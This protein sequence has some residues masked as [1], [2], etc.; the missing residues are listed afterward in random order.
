MIEF[1]NITYKYSSGDAAEYAALRSLSL[2]IEKG[3]FIGIA[4]HTGSGKSTAA[5]IAAGLINPTSGEILIDGK[6]FESAAETA[7]EL[8][9]RSWDCF[10]VSRA[11]AL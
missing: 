1:R 4:G 3:E 7:R 8:R 10:S 9:K 2:K 11:S 6:Q 5:Q